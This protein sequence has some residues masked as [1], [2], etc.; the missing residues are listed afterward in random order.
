MPV[1][2]ITRISVGTLLLQ[3]RAAD[4]AIRARFTAEISK[5]AD[6]ADQRR[7]DE[8]GAII[9]AMLLSWSKRMTDAAAKA[10]ADGRQAAREA[11]R[12]RLAIE[13]KAAGIMLTAHEW[14]V[15]SRQ[16]EDDG[17]AAHA[18]D[19]LA[20]QWRTLAIAAV[21]GAARKEKTTGQAIR[22]TARPM[23]LRI[24]RTAQTEVARAYSDEHS[25]ALVDIVEYDRAFRDGALAER[26]ETQT[27]RQWSAMADACPMC[28]P[29]D[30]VIVG[31]GEAFPGGFEPGY[32]HPHC[33]CIEVAV[34]RE[35]VVTKAA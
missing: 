28:L 23:R 2:T 30:D 4:T 22:S 35:N 14:Q 33:R 1:S 18:G 13:L 3:Q 31:I 25:D 16:D 7:K 10:I 12:K 34:E 5:A 11:A 15:R 20:G 9:L 26:L 27:A 32:V 6:E 29:L 21:L 17:Y 8:R 19:S 24:A